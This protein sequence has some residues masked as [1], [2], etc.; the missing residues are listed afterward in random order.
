MTASTSEQRVE[1][2]RRIN[3]PGRETTTK[4]GEGKKEREKRKK[5]RKD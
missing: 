3:Q 5:E 2:K 4:E 1:R